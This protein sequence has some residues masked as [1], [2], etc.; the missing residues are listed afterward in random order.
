[1]CSLGDGRSVLIDAMEIF[2]EKY[3]CAPPAY[4]N[5]E[6]ACGRRVSDVNDGRAGDLRVGKDYPGTSP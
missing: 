5:V 4:K 1:M 3:G 6:R 2:N